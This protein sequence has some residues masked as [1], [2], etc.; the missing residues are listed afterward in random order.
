MTETRSP[1]AAVVVACAAAVGL[2]A[3]S[4]RRSELE[5]TR[6]TLQL[7]RTSALIVSGETNLRLEATTIVALL[8]VVE[9]RLAETPSKM[10]DSP[11]PTKRESAA[12]ETK[13]CS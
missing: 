9:A 10:S 2:L 4:R 8:V 5:T 1:L 13:A 6:E 12:E 7:K 3:G 11:P